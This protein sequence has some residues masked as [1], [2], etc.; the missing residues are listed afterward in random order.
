MERWAVTCS[1]TGVLVLL[2]FNV[3]W[4]FGAGCYY[5]RDRVSGRSLAFT[6]V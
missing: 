5:P 6:D 2:T 4:S 3:R 1:G